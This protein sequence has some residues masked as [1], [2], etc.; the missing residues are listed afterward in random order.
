VRIL[1]IAGSLRRGSH[2]VALLRAAA[3]Q[4]PPT[5]ELVEWRALA[6]LP[7]YDEDLDVAVPPVAVNSLRRAIA[8]ADAVII[9]TPEYNGSVPGALKN[10]LDWASRPWPE[11]SLRGK[12]VC[13][14]GAST[15]LFGAVWAQSEVR[16][17]LTTI[18]A[19]VID[20]ELAIGQAHDAFDATGGL[21]DVALRAQ[22]GE[23]VNA[24]V[25]HRVTTCC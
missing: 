16:K 25:S 9:A 1:G 12:P 11:N 8:G 23:I 14:V 13:V 7:A 18:G 4:L 6:E 15:S 10:A 3:A 5:A 24:L 20:H 21:V 22:L 19:A 17:V 2:N